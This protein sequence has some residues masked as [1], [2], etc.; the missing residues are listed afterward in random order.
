MDAL[1]IITNGI[2]EIISIEELKKKLALGK[3]L[4]IK[5]GADP[6]APDLHLGHT[7]VLRKLKQF[8]DLGHEVIFIIGDFTASIGDPT[9]K[10]ETRKPLSREQ[11]LANAT[12]YQ[13]QVF[14]ILDRNKTK[15]VY[16]SEWINKLTPQDLI[17]LMAN[18]TVAQMLEREDF[19][20]RYTEGRAI[21]LHEFL[22]PILQGYDSVALKADVELGGTDQKF[23]LLVGRDLQ[24]AHGQPP[25]ALVIMPILEGLDGVNKMSKSLGNHI[26]ITEPANEMFG[27][28]MSL[29]DAL[30][31]RYYQL[32]TNLTFDTNEHPRD[33]KIKLGKFIVTQ[34][35]SAEAAEKATQNFLNVFSSGGIPDDITEYTLTENPITLIKLVS[36]TQLTESNGETKR[37]ATQKAISIDGTILLDPQA[38]I[39][40]TD[41]QVLRVGKRRFVK[42]RV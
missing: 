23:N 7:V 28:I 36:L 29:P 4:K 40:V 26:G 39:T 10:S 22:Y 6:S 15:V 12:T 9:G 41:G 35:H 20:K 2:L 34:Y 38:T 31:P 30:M 19:K 13:E 32:L 1:T 18:I 3:P 27:K 33:A 16:N 24:V 14:K 42:L 5:F 11:I 17:K 25:Q 8:Q 37:L 21:S